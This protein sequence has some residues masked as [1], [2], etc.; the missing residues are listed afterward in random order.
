MVVDDDETALQRLIATVRAALPESDAAAVLAG[1]AVRAADADVII[2]GA[3]MGWEAYCAHCRALRADARLAAVPLLVLTPP[4]LSA[5]ARRALLDAGA[6]ALQ[7]VPCDGA[8]LAAQ[9][10]ALAR[11]TRAGQTHAAAQHAAGD[12]YR[13]IL[14]AVPQAIFWKDPAGRYLGCNQAFARAAGLDDPAAVVGKFDHDL[15]WSQDAADVHR[16]G[17]REVLERQQTKL[18]FI[19]ALAPA[20]AARRWIDASK[21]PLL[22]AAGEVYAVLGVYEDITE[23][24]KAADALDKFFEQPGSLHLIARLD[25]VIERVNHGWENLLGYSPQ[26][27]V[28]MNF[29][30]LVHPDDHAATRQEM[31]NLSQGVTTFYFENRY[32]RHDGEYRL[33]AWSALASPADQ[34]IYAVAQDITER[35]AAEK[36]LRDSEDQ[37]RR[38]FEVSSVGVI[39]ADP[40]D[41][42][43]LRFN[44]R[45]AEITGYTRAELQDISFTR[46]TH[47]EDRENDWN[48]FAAAAQGETPHYINEKRYVRKDG[49]VIWVRVSAAFMR[50]AALRP[51]RSMAICE[52]ITDRK[53][54]ETALRESEERYRTLLERAPIGIAVH[55]DGHILFINPAAARLLGA[56]SVM[57]LVGKPIH[58]FVHP[59]SRPLMEARAQR[60]LVNGEALSPA[61][62]IFMRVD[63]T[64][65]DV[66]LSTA[67]LHFQGRTAVQVIAQDI[68]ERKRAEAE[69]SRL[70]AQVQAQAQQIRQILDTVPEGVILLDHEQ[71]VLVA[72]PTGMRDLKVLAAAT[73]GD[74]LTQLG[75]LPVAEMLATANGGPWHEIHAGPQTFEAIARPLAAAPL[76]TA[77]EQWVIVIDNVT[78]D[79]TLR[80]QL[81]QQERLAAVGQLAAGIAHDFNN[82]L[83][84]IA[85]QGSMAAQ[86]PLLPER[87]GARLHV[88]NEQAAQATRLIQQMLDFSRRAVLER[89]PL[90]LAALLQD[91]VELLTR[92]LPE[93]I[94]VTFLRGGDDYIVLADATRIQQMVMNL[95]VNARDAMPQGGALRL[96]LTRYATPPQP[97]LAEGAWVSLTVAD[98]GVG[99]APEAMA[100]MFEPFFTTKPRG[101]G[102]GL[103][104]AQVYGIV[105]Q[106]AGE[107]SVNS[108]EGEGTT[109]TIYLPAVA[110]AVDS[111]AAP[112]PAPPPALGRE[113]TILLV[114]DNPILLEAMLDILA[115][116]GYTAIGAG[117]GREALAILD[118]QARGIDL[119]L[120]DLI[121]PQ[122]GGDTLLAKMRERGLAT[123]VAILSGHPLEGELIELKQLGL[124]GWLLKPPDIKELAQLLAQVL[125]A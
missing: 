84:I 89:Q 71:C 124:A 55:A 103:G 86:T 14:D 69:R 10:N 82:I 53:N 54:A 107:I 44:D 22:D 73:L 97:E 106:H 1:N 30:Q 95:A 29:L 109:F 80:A 114:E 6:N 35:I 50:D 115:L 83:A 26:E 63:G 61:E 121:M 27:L 62:Y 17:D 7:A 79:R 25:G 9:V 70:L 46:L 102:T 112:A 20:T 34:L 125:A 19:E 36:A 52:D 87:V 104:L 40:N 16:A 93:N 122:M 57:E 8:E 72:N 3:G 88:I 117:N 51:Y 76:G 58:Q 111:P 37:F 21:L 56:Q 123:P 66:E 42:R 59:A 105:K 11:L 74:R 75:D 81:Q 96:H 60:L 90:D 41:G 94:E 12:A 45:F 32:R 85:L 48:I 4:N 38:L 67:L 13:L 65:V 18:H 28:G 2:L 110:S 23:H 64:P 31:Y 24:R 39:Q 15:P 47:P 5:D 43:L 78:R 100:H 68:T 116:L 49:S 118:E 77:G 108:T 92:T 99:I 98:T 91:Q 113:A 119:V 120:T 33:L 101:R